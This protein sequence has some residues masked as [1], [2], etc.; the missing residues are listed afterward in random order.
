[1]APEPTHPILA[2]LAGGR[3]YY[4]WVV[5]ACCF[6]GA[7]TAFS[8]IYSFSVFFGH[9]SAAFEQSQG[10][11]S[12][13]FSLQ[14]VVTYGAA[15]A[16]GLIVDRFGARRL[17][18]LGAGL[19][20]AGLIGA[21]QFQSFVAVVLSYGVVAAAGL[22]LVYV[23]AYATTPRW[24][25]RRRGTATAVATAGGGAGIL[26]GPPMASTLIDQ[27]GW[28]TA[29][30]VITAGAVAVLGV[31]AL[32]V[33]DRPRDVGLDPAELSEFPDGS[34]DVDEDGADLRARLGRIAEIGRSG[35]FLLVFLSYVCLGVPIFVFAAHAV[36]FTRSVGLGEGL[37]VLAISVVGGMNFFGKFVAGPVS[38]AIGI[39]RTLAACGVLLGLPLLVLS[40]VHAPAVVL[41]AVVVFGLGYG[42]AIA[43]LSPTVADLFGTTDINALFGLTSVAFAVTGSVGP[44]LAGVGY[45]TTGS[46]AVP[47]VV[48]GIL[49]LL[50]VPT[51]EVARRRAGG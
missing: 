13:L 27:F 16:L 42:G 3:V 30:L 17:L 2:R 40:A 43:L 45:D 9:I 50:S 36:E 41:A 49:G 23:I 34:A 39:P 19:I 24:F 20:G 11:T 12:L 31:V 15:A 51:L 4:G 26:L 14:S 32:L 10:N 18:A 38:D 21:S 28:Q 22:S 47:L 6:L 5:V 48:A 1:M 37:G 46:Y 44:Y 7:L 35:S 29:Y 25:D 8:I 33:A